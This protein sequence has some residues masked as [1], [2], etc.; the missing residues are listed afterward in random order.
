MPSA[1]QLLERP[2]ALLL[3]GCT[4]AAV[5]YAMPLALDLPLMD[6][7]E[8][9]HASIVQEMCETGEYLMPRYR[10]ELFRDKPPLFFWLQCL[11]VNVLGA[12]EVGIRLPGLLCGLLGALTTA[13]LA[14]ELFDRRTAAV[15]AFFQATM[16]LPVALAQVAVH[17]VLLV[18]CVNLALLTFWR[19]ERSGSRRAWFGWTATLGIVLGAALLTKGLLGLALVAIVLGGYRLLKRQIDVPLIACGLIALAIAVL[20]A[21]PWYVLMSLRDPNYLYYYFVERHLMGFLTA[22]QVHGD[23]PKWYYAPILLGGGLPWLG[24]LPAA[25]YD[26]YQRR[27]TA[28]CEAGATADPW[29]DPRL[30]CWVWLLGGTL[31]LC[32]ARSKL[33]TYILPMFPAVSLLAATVWARWSRGELSAGIAQHVSQSFCFAA[34]TGPLVLPIALWAT[35]DRFD[36]RYS[37]PAIALTAIAAASSWLPLWN[38]DPRRL[39]LTLVKGGT[40]LALTFIVI[41]TV[42]VPPVAEA[43]SARTLA[44]HLNRRDRLP[45]KLIIADERIGS[46]LFYLRP[47]FRRQLRDEQIVACKFSHWDGL[48]DLP[49]DCLLAVPR[50]KARRGERD[51]RLESAPF[52]VVGH[53]RL[54]RAADARIPARLAELRKSAEASPQ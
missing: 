35:A 30:L 49:S 41:M 28:R 53:Y 24:Y 17:D 7:S 6:G 18:P 21:S 16:V 46:I 9:V 27:R 13:W 25:A 47:D 34:A 38:Y 5:L 44:E 11:S 20:V 15:A 4:L 50:A 37:W 10:G 32:V 8:A 3:A 52:E 31:F 26:G 12:N 2:V 40:S 23:Q 48:T 36:V 45:A 51:L 43:M 14:A 1:P 39:A 42:L 19:V 29:A 54:Y 22:S 33:A